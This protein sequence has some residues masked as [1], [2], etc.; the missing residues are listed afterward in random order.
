VLTFLLAVRMLQRQEEWPV[1]GRRV[2][3]RGMLENISGISSCIN[4]I[5]F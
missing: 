1:S 3:V 2:W 4:I 5:N